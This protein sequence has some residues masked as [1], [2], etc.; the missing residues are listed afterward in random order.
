MKLYKL[1]LAIALLATLALT[2]G[3]RKEAELELE[4][5]ER[6]L[7]LLQP[8]QTDADVWIKN[9]LVDVYNIDAIWHWTYREAGYKHDLVP[10]AEENVVPF[11]NVVEQIFLQGYLEHKG[12]NWF[13][14]LVP[15]Q[16]LLV[17]GWGYNND[18]TITL[19]QAEGGQKIVFY[20]VDH[21]DAA[22][23]QNYPN[24]REAIH[25]MFHEFGHILHQNKLFSED[26]EKI[27]PEGYTAQWNN[28]TELSSRTAGFMSS[29][30]RLNQNEDFVELIAFYTTLTSEQWEA[31]KL[32]GVKNA[33]SALTEANEKGDADAI[34]KATLN[35]EKAQKGVASI[36]RKIT[37]V[38]DYL[39][40]S[41]EVDLDVLRDI[42]L[43]RSEEVFH[44]PEIFPNA[45]S[46]GTAA[47]MVVSSPYV[48]NCVHCS[49]EGNQPAPR[50]THNNSERE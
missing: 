36:D 5:P 23:Q 26:F 46:G 18:G 15:K 17:G 12:K 30:S 39:K 25:T 13:L 28:E 45:A 8:K 21:W 43:E 48:H 27:T 7:L 42:V 29:Y 16:L 3:C 32:Q 6:E 14:P 11:L 47:P 31:R 33:T 20:G 1:I 4:N 2:S 37:M 49:A 41:W 19:G 50:H 22:P 34:Q 35:L 40:A 38:K 9:N 10:P 44:N 24:V